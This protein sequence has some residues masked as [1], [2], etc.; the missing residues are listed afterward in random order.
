MFVQIEE[1]PSMCSRSLA[2]RKVA[3]RPSTITSG[4][5]SRAHHSGMFVNGCQTNRLSVAIRSRSSQSLIVVLTQETIERCEIVRGGPTAPVFAFDDGFQRTKIIQEWLVVI[6]PGFIDVS[7][8]L[9]L[10]DAT[11]V[12]RAIV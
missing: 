12:S 3:P 6:S 2:S 10:A 8:C 1:L 7:F 11:Q 9:E 5:C 4:S